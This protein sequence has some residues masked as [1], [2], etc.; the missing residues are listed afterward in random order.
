M[1]VD[2]ID[3]R[4]ECIQQEVDQYYTTWDEYFEKMF[5]CGCSICRGKKQFK[6]GI[7]QRNYINDNLPVGIIPSTID[8]NPIGIFYN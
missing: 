3:T 2:P 5:V 7:I 4:N 1:I 8:L 6:Q